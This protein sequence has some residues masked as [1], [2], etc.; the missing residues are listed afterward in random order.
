VAVPGTMILAARAAAPRLTHQAGVVQR[1]LLVPGRY[2]I[3]P[4]YITR[5][6]F[7][8]LFDSNVR[9]GTHPWAFGLT[10][11]AAM[12]T[13]TTTNAIPMNPLG[14]AVH[15]QGSS[16]NTS[17]YSATPNQVQ[18]TNVPP[19]STH[20]ATGASAQTATPRVVPAAPPIT[21]STPVS[22]K[23]SYSIRWSP[24]NKCITLILAL[25]ALIVTLYFAIMSGPG[26]LA[27]RRA[28]W[29]SRNDFRATCISELESGLS[30]S[31]S[32]NR[33]LSQ[34]AE[35]PRG[36][37]KRDDINT[38]AY[39]VQWIVVA[40]VVAALVSA[41]IYAAALSF[42]TL[43]LT[44]VTWA[45]FDPYESN[46]Q[47]GITRVFERNQTTKKH[48]KVLSSPDQF[49]ESRLSWTRVVMCSKPSQWSTSDG[50]RVV[51][52]KELCQLSK[53]HGVNTVKVPL[54]PNKDISH[55]ILAWTPPQQQSPIA[56]P[57]FTIQGRRIHFPWDA[58]EGG[59]TGVC[60]EYLYVLLESKLLDQG[61]ALE[62]AKPEVD[63]DPFEL[64][65]P[66]GHQTYSKITADRK[67]ML[68]TG[69]SYG[70]SDR[71][72]QGRH[73]KS[74]RQT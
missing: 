17:K 29:S 44:A 71:Y 36:L 14:H 9:I 59:H 52:W 10:V 26:S 3:E 31:P 68:H 72:L 12:A 45:A 8:I 58:E 48:S 60:R 40:F 19:S 13:I 33:T 38:S 24:V 28:I 56:S 43:Q 7:T 22:T 42:D 61:S 63:W 47:D 11:L 6:H 1:C 21:A 69:N 35:P 74:N 64:P 20:N 51:H 34:P 50:A 39:L 25:L 41:L 65:E 67:A 5:P 70:Y 73:A 55:L 4:V 18:T 37:E 32:C 30:L 46:K 66:K 57:P 2:P 15:Q 62:P 27:D 16:S 23:K 49:A 53:A 54:L